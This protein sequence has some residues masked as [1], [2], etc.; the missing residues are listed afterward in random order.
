MTEETNV[1]IKEQLAREIIEEVLSEVVSR[2][3]TGIG[4]GERPLDYHN[5]PHT[6]SV[7]KEVKIL[8]GD[9]LTLGKIEK[10][11][12]LLLDLGASGHDLIEDF[13]R[14]INERKSADR[15][16]QIMTEAG[17]F[18]GE[19]ISTVDKVIMGT[20]TFFVDDVMYQ[21]A[22]EDYLSQLLA[23]ADLANL[24]KETE[25]YFESS[26]RYMRELNGNQIPDIEKQIKFWE[27][28][29]TL[30][31]HHKYYTDE[32]KNR[33]PNQQA[34]LIATQKRLEDLRRKKAL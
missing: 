14:G 16:R 2:Y 17:V 15:M 28:N 34:N 5:G 6:D 29:L 32:A 10:D 1:L 26:E 21:S 31:T 18:S 23:D 25:I 19:E 22:G 4:D 7:R 9:A 3:G 11:Q 8:A 30:L 33:Y 20:V 13:D 27:S 24:G 12:I